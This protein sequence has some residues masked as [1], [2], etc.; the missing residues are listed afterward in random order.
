MSY[1]AAGSCVI[2]ANQAGNGTYAAAAQAQ[3]MITVTSSQKQTQSI[4]FTNPPASGTVDG[5]ATLSA[6]AS[7]GLPV[8]LS[9][10]PAS[11][12]GV[13]TLSGST[14][15][16]TAAGSCVI[17][18]NQAGNGTYAAAAQAQQMITVTGKPQSIT[19]TNPPA[20]GTVDGT[21]TLS[22]TA[23]SGLPV[24]LSVDPAS[25]A[26]VCTLSGS[27]V[28]YTAAGSCVIDANQ[29]GNGTY[30]AAAQAQQMITVTGKPQ[31]IT[32]SNPPA[33]GTV[34]GTATLSATASS[35]LP[36]ALSVDPA[37]GPG[38]CTLSGSTVTY[39]AAGSCVID[40]NQAGNG[41]YAA[42]PQAQQMIT[43]TGKPQSITFSNPPASGTVG[44]S[45]TLSATASS[46]LLVVLSVDPNSGAG[47]CTLSG[48]RVTYAAAGSS[49]VI[50]ANQ[51]GNGTYAA[52]AQAQLSIKVHQ[53]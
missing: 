21:A 8:A 31:S 33:S 6:T 18:A 30:A 11:G 15:T 36:V 42:A 40:A 4:T 52:A 19:F 22:A 12:A 10:D 23:S 13:C 9:V 29:A 44:D 3:Q 24:A 34:D 26:G 32:F 7:S 46:G 2:D 53:P 25:G 43:V 48:S 27:T 1:T 14:V 50:D 37:S 35:R 49:C 51:A 45:A 41:T 47:V 38:V 28:T 17:D 39:A 16:Y 5:T 20:S